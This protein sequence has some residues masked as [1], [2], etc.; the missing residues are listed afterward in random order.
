[1]KLV[2]F[3]I[4]FVLMTATPNYNSFKSEQLK[5]ERVKLAYDEKADIVR[6]HCEKAG[7]DFESLKIFIRV[8]KLERKVEIWGVDNQTNDY[9][10]INTYPFCASSGTLGPKRAKGDGQI[11][12]GIYHI[13]RFNPWSSF[14]LSL[15]LNYPNQADKKKSTA[16]DL[17]GDIFIHGNCVTIGCMPLSDEKIKEVYVMAVQSGSN[18]TVKIPVHIFPFDMIEKR[19]LSFW[20][21]HDLQLINFWKTLLPYYQFFDSKKRVPKLTINSHGDYKL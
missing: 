10:L 5:N 17:G 12:E 21:N 16:K 3:N 8:L 11:P 1:M 13:D 2:L 9:K 20:S 18:G 7:L 6:S 4:F 15:G 19:N 14:H